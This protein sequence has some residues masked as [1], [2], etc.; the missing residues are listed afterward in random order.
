M[1]NGYM[2]E[3][4]PTED[5][6]DVSVLASSTDLIYFFREAFAQCV[7]LSTGQ[8]LAQLASLF[9]KWLTTYAN[10]LLSKRLPR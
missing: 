10:T 2:S 5:D 1:M 8:P 9:A 4:L 7:K 3:G 6:H